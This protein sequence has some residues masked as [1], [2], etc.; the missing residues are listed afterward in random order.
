MQNCLETI[1]TVQAV[2]NEILAINW[3]SI[4]QTSTWSIKP[5]RDRFSEVVRVLNYNIPSVSTYCNH[6]TAPTTEWCS[7]LQF[8]YNVVLNGGITIIASN[9]IASKFC[10]NFHFYF[11][12]IVEPE[13]YACSEVY[14]KRYCS[15]KNRLCRLVQCDWP[16]PTHE[17]SLVRN[18]T[19]E[20]KVA[21]RKH[22]SECFAY[23]QIRLAKL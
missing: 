17:Y 2:I 12:D 20:K 23:Q 13:V 16:V 9:N 21:H 4:L 1:S 8:G 22:R 18:T 7:Y 3:Q 11:A 10:C 5:M 14:L 15:D 19:T 6:N